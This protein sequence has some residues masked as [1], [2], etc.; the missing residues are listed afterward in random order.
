MYS[1]YAAEH[2]ASCRY[3][4]NCRL[5]LQTNTKSRSV[6]CVLSC[7][8]RHAGCG[9]RGMDVEAAA[10]AAEA[11]EQGVA[12][13]GGQK[14]QH[15]HW[16]AAAAAAA[17]EQAVMRPLLCAVLALHAL[18]CGPRLM[19]ATACTIMALQL[20]VV[21][22]STCFVYCCSTTVGREQPFLETL[23]RALSAWYIPDNKK[24]TCSSLDAR[25][26]TSPETAWAKSLD[27]AGPDCQAQ[28]G[29]FR[30]SSLAVPT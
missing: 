4:F 9:W 7:A 24:Q 12:G 6:R 21:C 13:R 28:H 27:T 14:P 5:P 25:P 15:H 11:G 23:P 10:G 22:R 30:F 20:R 8:R 29:V 2:A 26:E 3:A 1:A 18:C 19:L 17:A 16:P